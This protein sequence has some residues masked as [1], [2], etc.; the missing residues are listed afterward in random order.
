[1]LGNVHASYT[2][3]T[4]RSAHTLT[5]RVDNVG[6]TLY[7][8]HLSF[9]KDAVPEVGRSLKLVYGVKF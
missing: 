1:M 8:N 7:R 9:I 2:F 5:A 3:T 6:D 4:G